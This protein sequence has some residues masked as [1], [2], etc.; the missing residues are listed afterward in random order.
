MNNA[1]DTIATITTRAKAYA[2]GLREHRNN[3]FEDDDIAEVV[4]QDVLDNNDQCDYHEVAA[5]A[6]GYEM[7]KAG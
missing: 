4:N 1:Y 7:F 6:M 2:N 5:I 3:G